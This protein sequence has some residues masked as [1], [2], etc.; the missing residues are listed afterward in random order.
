MATPQARTKILCTMGPS[1]ADETGIKA[2]VKNGMAVARLNCSHGDLAMRKRYLNV[3]R[4]VEKQTGTSLAIMLDLQGP[5]LRVGDLRAPLELKPGEIWRMTSQTAPV[6]AKVIPLS[7]SD[8]AACVSV[9]GSLYMDDGLIKT[10]VV[11]KSGRDVWVRVVFGG[12]LESRKGIN[13]PFHKGK[14]PV[15]SQ[16]DLADLAWGLANGVDMIALSFVR[17]AKDLA[18]LRRVILRQHPANMPLLIAKIEKPEAVEDM[19]AIIQASDGILIARGD[20]GIE[21][22]PEKVPVVQ[23]RLI[24]RCRFFKKPVIVATQMLDSMRLNP[25]PTRAEVS[26]VANAIYAGVDAVLLTGETSSGKYPIEACTMM[27]KI[28][29]E[30]EAHLIG[31]SFRKSPADFGIMGP[32]EAMMFNV[33]QMADDMGVKAIVVL[34]KQGKL[35]KVLSKLHPKQPIFSLASNLPA[36]RQLNLFWG[37]F[38]LMLTKTLADDRIANGVALLKKRQIV[39]TGDGLL[40]LY[41]DFQ[42]ENLNIKAVTV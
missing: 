3:L 1:V 41:R 30:V 28:V 9:G 42:S 36:Y 7:F 25:V 21:L 23:K 14:R 27:N 38:P 37:V 8:L 13:I 2:L 18:V 15:L 31:K 35:T 17:Q 29:H 19:D 6:G 32:A 26:D 10:E 5:K 24:E 33:M 40:F 22:P 12:S 4:K 34:T 20:L 16:K 39:R 11:R